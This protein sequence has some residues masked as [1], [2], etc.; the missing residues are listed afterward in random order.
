M[1]KFNISRKTFLFPSSSYAGGGGLPIDTLYSADGTISSNRFVDAG[2]NILEFNN[3]GAFAIN[4][5]STVG[6]I[7]SGINLTSTGVDMNLSTTGGGV[8]RLNSDAGISLTNSTAGT[9]GIN[10]I[11]GGDITLNTTGADIN[12]VAVGNVNIKGLAYPT[13]D[14]TAG[15]VI[16]TNG[17]G[18]LN[19]IDNADGI[20]S[21]DGTMQTGIT[22][23]TQGSP[24][25]QLVFSKAFPNTAMA[26]FTDTTTQSTVVYAGQIDVG[27]FAG[28]STLSTNI[29]ISNGTGSVISGMQLTGNSGLTADKQVLAFNVPVGAGTNQ[30]FIL[31]LPSG[32]TDTLATLSD[33]SNTIYNGDSVVGSNRIATITDTLT[34]R[35]GFIGIT[36]ENYTPTCALDLVST[37]GAGSRICSTRYSNN[38]NSA[39]YISLKARGTFATPTAILTGDNL[40]QY[41]GAGYDGS[42]FGNRDAGIQFEASENFTPT[43]KG[44]SIALFTTPNGTNTVTRMA[45]LR[46]SGDYALLRGNLITTGAGFGVIV[47]DSVDGN[48]YLINTINGVLQTTLIP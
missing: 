40:V 3:I 47:T 46:N 37:S 17:A 45:E 29:D 38:Q 5:N 12:L 24:F 25:D 23:V 20:Y 30:Q 19:F 18:I 39:G 28:G 26:Q 8:A 7:S 35:D 6:I 33:I 41:A 31:S 48:N 27:E 15:Q 43:A 44:T 32:V 42:A 22:T 13:A 11:G 36:D 10:N 16:G 9:I 14:G 2:N 34:F 21:G 4:G 1:D